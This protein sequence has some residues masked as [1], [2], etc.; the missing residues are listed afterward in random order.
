MQFRNIALAAIAATSFGAHAALTTYAPWDVVNAPTGL[1]GVQFNVLTS[2]GIT[3]AMG[4]HAYK[5]GVTLPNDGVNTYYAQSGTYAPDGL[6]R[7]NWSFDFAWD[8]GGCTACNIKLRVD[9][10]P[11]AGV[12]LVTLFDTSIA[13]T[14]TALFGSASVANQYFQSWNMEMGFVTAL[15]GYNFNPFAATSTAFS[16][17]ATD[18]AG[19]VISSGVTV[20]VPEPG[21]LALVGLALAGTAALRRRVA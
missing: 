20:N 18:A 3:L 17:E 4:A 9:T 2:G 15:L 1:N 12:N 13:G 6:N 21:S 16:L 19:S 11:T 5:N 14:N 8:L 7:A 10:D